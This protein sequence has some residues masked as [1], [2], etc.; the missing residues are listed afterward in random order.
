[1]KALLMFAA[2]AALSAQSPPL[3][4][5]TPAGRA[6]LQEALGQALQG[7]IRPALAR[8]RAVGDDQFAGPG[9]AIRTCILSR[10]GDASND[11]PTTGLPP[12]ATRALALYRAYWRAGLLD[13]AARPAAEERLRTGLASL[14]GLPAATDVNAME[15]PLAT[16][17]EAEHMHVLSGVTPP[18]REL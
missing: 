4:A 12:S 10:F 5:T 9:A 14:L 11:G 6:A 7:D 18:F 2:W 15:A 17:L 3:P 16:R 1:M 8:L 13:P